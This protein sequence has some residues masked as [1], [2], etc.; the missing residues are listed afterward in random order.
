MDNSGYKINVFPRDCGTAY[1]I[2]EAE[3]YLGLKNKDL[4]KMKYDELITYIDK[5]ALMLLNE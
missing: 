5:I 3:S 4:Y 2:R 1:V